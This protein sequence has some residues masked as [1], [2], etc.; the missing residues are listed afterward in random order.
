MLPKYGQ[1][2]KESKELN[3]TRKRYNPI[4]HT[5]AISDDMK[6]DFR[7]TRNF[8]AVYSGFERSKAELLEMISSKTD[9]RKVVS[10]VGMGG[11]GKTTLAK[12]VYDSKELHERFL[13][14]LGL[15]FHNPLAIFGGKVAGRSVEKHQG[16][17]IQVNHCTDHL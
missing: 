6:V 10:V 7:V 15:L 17:T 12:K 2:R 4:Q 8:A 5:D 16:L 9:G 13:I 14:V 11:L 1:S 3:Q